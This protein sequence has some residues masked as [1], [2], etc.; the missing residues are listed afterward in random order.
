MDNQK[1]TVICIQEARFG[2][3]VFGVFHEKHDSSNNDRWI[4]AR[5]P[6][7][8]GPARSTRTVIPS[9]DGREVE[10]PASVLRPF[11]SQEEA[12]RAFERWSTKQ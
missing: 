10:R 4:I 3:L 12:L 11:T 8:W 1:I 7:S 6:L 5:V 2:N 9:P